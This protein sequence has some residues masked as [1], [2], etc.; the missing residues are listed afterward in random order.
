MTGKRLESRINTCETVVLS[1]LTISGYSVKTLTDAGDFRIKKCV[2]VFAQA[3]A[4][5]AHHNGRLKTM[6]LK[7]YLKSKFDKLVRISCKMYEKN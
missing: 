3:N 2:I 4:K 6:I 5:K 7:S 1:F